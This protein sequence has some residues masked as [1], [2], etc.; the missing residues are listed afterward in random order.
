MTAGRQGAGRQGA[1][2]QGAGRQGAARQ[3]AGRQG[4]KV[5]V[6][7]CRFP[8]EPF[9][10]R[11]FRGLA[12]QGVELWIVGSRNVDWEH[13]RLHSLVPPSKRRLRAR[14]RGRRGRGPNQDLAFYRKRR[15]DL[16]YFPWNS[17]AVDHSALMDIFPAVVSCRG[18]QILIA[19]TS[20]WRRD[21]VEGFPAMFNRAAGVHCVSEDILHAAT[22]LGLDAAKARVVNPAVD[23][24]VFFP[25]E[26]RSE[27]P[28]E[29]LSVGS[30]LWRKGFEDAL[31][32][33]GHLRDAGVDFRYHLVGHG[34]DR[35]RLRFAVD[36]L[37]LTDRVVFH[38][39][40][41]PSQV[42]D[43]MQRCHIYVLSSV[44]EGIA[45]V[46][47]EAMACGMAVVSTRCGGMEEAVEHE[48]HGLL[49]PTRDPEAMAEAVRRLAE[50]AE[51]RRRLGE[52]ARRRIE[53]DF[54]LDDQ[55]EA[56]LALFLDAAG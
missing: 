48:T 36:D 1:G 21:M 53:R 15:F 42:R 45:N 56:I 11:L 38:G 8:P 26:G 9:L 55:V 47:L 40:Q 5:L 39:A 7:G 30:L 43:H 23:P 37:D 27:G 52:V 13:G 33:M 6:V 41:T 3:G 29:I 20:P 54:R 12:E 46:V 50:D 34:P 19:P 22:A 44:C 32:A 51:L 31:V 18:S 25:P 14:F 49:V 4:L 2:R 28:V 10:D 24:A 17:A 16:V 35:Q